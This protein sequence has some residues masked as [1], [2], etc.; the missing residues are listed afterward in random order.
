MSKKIIKLELCQY[1][2]HRFCFYRLYTSVDATIL[3]SLKFHPMVK[4]YTVLEQLTVRNNFMKKLRSRKNKLVLRTDLVGKLMLS[5]C[6]QFTTN[7]LHVKARGSFDAP[8][9]KG[10]NRACLQ[11]PSWLAGLN[12]VHSRTQPYIPT[13]LYF[14]WIILYLMAILIIK[15]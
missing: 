9:P 11:S 13:M 12:H 5:T 14:L 15:E 3:H 2:G 6:L 10:R 8:N 1:W 4:P 7:Q